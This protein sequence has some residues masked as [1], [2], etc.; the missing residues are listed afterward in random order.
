[1][2]TVRIEQLCPDGERPRLGPGQS[3]LGHPAE[4]SQTRGCACADGAA[5]SAERMTDSR[6]DTDDRAEAG[7]T[8]SP[9]PDDLTD[10][11]VQPGGEAVRPAAVPGAYEAD[12]AERE[13]GKAVKPGN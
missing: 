3:V 2:R 5:G 6:P 10:A 4:T 12:E 11:P 9:G 7:G 13:R 8:P 1:M